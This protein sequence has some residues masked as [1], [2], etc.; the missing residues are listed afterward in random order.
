VRK[1]S[2]IVDVLTKEH[3]RQS[4]L[5]DDTCRVHLAPIARSPLTTSFCLGQTIQVGVPHKRVSS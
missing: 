5:L 4:E 2:Q 1:L 3:G